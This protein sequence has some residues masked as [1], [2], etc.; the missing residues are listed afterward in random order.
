MNP[1]AIKPLI[2]IKRHE[3][4]PENDRLSVV[5][6]V[7]MAV[8]RSLL[9]QVEKSEDG[10]AAIVVEINDPPADLTIEAYRPHEYK[11]LRYVE[12]LKRDGQD[13]WTTLAASTL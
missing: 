5:M 11:N 7:D 13:G 6:L 12:N 3:D 10:R 4:K 2:Q 1:S 8:L 9:D